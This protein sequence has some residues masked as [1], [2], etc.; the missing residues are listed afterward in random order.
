[1][2]RCIDNGPGILSASVLGC[3][4]LAV[5]FIFIA[6]PTA[7][8]GTAEM[9]R[10]FSKAGVI[11][12]QPAKDPV[13][14]NLEDINGNPVR[15]SDFRGKIV[16]LN[17]WTTWC[18]TCRSEMPSIEKL[19]QKLK[20]KDFAVVT[21]NLQE[22]A[23]Q[24]EAFFREF[25]LTVTALLDSTGEIGTSFAIRA[26]PTTYILDKTGR[27]IG[28]VDGPREWDSRAFLALFE[29]LAN[30]DATATLSEAAD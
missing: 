13:E 21:V 27:I 28:R 14:I 16:F 18:P 20:H 30:A 24:V 15:L 1:M 26:I 11:K 2:K 5:L 22:S 9:D 8:T 12:V 3:S 29:N 7:K 25:K 10:L 17:F 4:A 23:S 6:E 19:H